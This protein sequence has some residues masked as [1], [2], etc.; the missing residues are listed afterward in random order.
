MLDVSRRYIRESWLMRRKGI[1][2]GPI[3]NVY[4]TMGTKPLSFY[5]ENVFSNPTHPSTPGGTRKNGPR[6]QAR[7]GHQNTTRELIS[8]T[9]SPTS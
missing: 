2:N 7:I 8:A 9:A 1:D 4:N 6:A 5:T 3:T